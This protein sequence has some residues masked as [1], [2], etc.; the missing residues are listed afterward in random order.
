MIIRIAVGE[1]RVGMYIDSMECAWIDNPFW[2]RSFAIKTDAELA[3]LVASPIAHVSIDTTKGRGVTVIPTAERRRA[4]DDSGSSG[5]ADAP[6]AVERRR[7]RSGP[8]AGDLTRALDRSKEHVMALFREARLG[9]AIELGAVTP[10]VDD[11]SVALQRDPAAFI[12]VTRLKLNNEYTYLHS[13][14][15]CALMVNLAMHLGLPEDE[16]REIGAAGLLHD[17]GKVATP[18]DIL[19]KAGTLGDE[20][21]LVM[22]RH[23]RDGHA[24]LR[25]HA[26]TSQIALDVC[27]HHHER[28]DGSGYPEGLKGDA[29]SLHARIAAICD[30]YDAVTSIRPYKRPWSPHEAL[31]RMLEWEG[32]FDPVLLDAFIANL[33]IQPL[34]ALVRLN[35]NRLGIVLDGGEDPAFPL[36]R[37]FFDVPDASLRPIEDVDTSR[38]PILRSERGDYWFPDRWPDILASVQAGE[39]PMPLDPVPIAAAG[40]R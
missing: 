33:G 39:T 24:M 28:L 8:Q 7:R 36:V 5:A 11:I 9:K 4:I 25:E 15:V 31:A 6:R 35:S 12:K 34:G 30:V 19:D 26:D 21:W 16:V 37:T 18:L 3:K 2:R 38:D 10:V 29:I 27:L 20:E 1:A 32:H 22:R 40:G 14:A 23:P 13:I 17:I